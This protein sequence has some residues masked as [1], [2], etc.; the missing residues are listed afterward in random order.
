[1]SDLIKKDYPAVDNFEG[2]EDGVE[3][4]DRP[5]GAGVI[6][7]TSVK[8][9][10]DSTWVTR[11][12]IELESNLE[13]VAVDVARVVQK[14]EDGSPIETIVLEPHQKFPDI[15][16]MNEAIPRDQWVEGP[17]G[18]PRGPWQAQHILY[19]VDLMTMEKYTF[20]TG[21]VGGR[22]AI[23]ELRDKL[24]WMRRVR[25]LN[26]YA[27]IVLRDKFMNTRFGGRQRPFF[28]IVRWVK[29][30]TEGGDVA[31]LPAPATPVADSPSL[32]LEPSLKEEL[33]DSID[34]LPG[35][36]TAETPPKKPAK[37]GKAAA[38][39]GKRANTLEAG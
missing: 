37:P 24:V 15:E 2:W 23:G 39:N 19:M 14:W 1:M 3:G 30:G 34:D 35:L 31:A 4:H 20:A 25:G 8:F 9:T 10:N 22:I 16:S 6:Q 32:V 11:D 5:Q 12:K 7:G 26:V 36:G 21:T 17:D 28:S 27:V 29:L 13:L 38:K 33:N 18:K